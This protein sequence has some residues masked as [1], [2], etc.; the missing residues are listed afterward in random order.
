MQRNLLTVESVKTMTTLELLHYL[1]HNFQ[2][3]EK[4]LTSIETMTEHEVNEV[5]NRW[6]NDGTLSR[7]VSD[8][9]IASVNEKL[10]LVIDQANKGLNTVPLIR[11]SVSLKEQTTYPEG[12]NNFA[13]DLICHVPLA[14]Q[15]NKPIGE[16][17]GK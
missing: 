11:Q 15:Y 3:L 1:L 16:N 14:K 17:Y 13:Y 12:V 9:I 8:E 2:E 10:D 6:L 4:Q 7:L 5:L